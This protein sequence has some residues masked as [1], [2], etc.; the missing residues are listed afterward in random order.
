MARFFSATLALPAALAVV[1][2]GCSTRTLV[3]VDPVSC[4]DGGGPGCAAGLLD[5]LVGFW[6]LN[7]P[8]GSTTAR[9]SS[10]WGNDG[11]L[12][13]LDPSMAW[14]AGGPEGDSLAPQTKGYVNVATSASIDSVTDQVTVMGWMYLDGPVDQY[15]TVISRQIG[16]GFGQ[17][18]HLS[19]TPTMNPGLYITT[20]TGG[21][22]DRVP[23]EVVP[24]QTW[25]HL[26]GTYD[27]TTAR[28]YLNGVEVNSGAISGPFAA[29][30]DP[31]VLGG[32][33]NNTNLAVSELI[34]GQL[35]DVMLYRR[36]L[37][38]NEIARIEGG[39]LLPAGAARPDAGP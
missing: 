25:F 15:A 35:A 27:G 8:P 14:V 9:D 16:T 24:Q 19:V 30:T 36:A 20:T 6:R 11:M 22:L 26:A 13:G 33:G 3:V 21:Q 1:A 23:N 29:E 32:N 39:A 37:A 28:L 7:D 10:P 2:A 17:H 34:P 31:V 18:Y 38:A 4:P 5:G 12:A